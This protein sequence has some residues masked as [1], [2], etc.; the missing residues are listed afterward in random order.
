MLDRELDTA[1]LE[2]KG[3]EAVTVDMS[4]LVTFQAIYIRIVKS[5]GDSCGSNARME[6]FY[7]HD[8]WQC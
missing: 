7:N 8:L 1:Y 4:P 5:S 2:F 3:C 6:H